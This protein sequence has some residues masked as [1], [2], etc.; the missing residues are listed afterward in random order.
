[1]GLETAAI[2][3]I[4]TA[5]ASAG[6]SAGQAI[7]ASQAARNASSRATKAFDEAMNE[8]SANR[9]AGLSLPREAME[10][11]IEAN[12]SAGAD[13][14]QAGRESERGAAAI[15]GQVYRGQTEAQREIAGDIGKQLMGLEAATAEEE[16]RLAGARANLNLAEAQG[17]Q[18][19]AAQAGAQSAAAVKGIFTGLESA[20][21]QYLEASELYKSSEGVKQYD[22][23][24]KQY[25]KAAA[26][27]TLNK[28]FL[29]PK[30]N[31]PLPFNMVISKLTGNRDIS[32]K[33]G[34]MDAL[35]AKDYLIKSPNIIKSISGDVFSRGYDTGMDI[36]APKRNLSSSLN[37]FSNP[38]LGFNTNPFGN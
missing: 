24:L 11:Q 7:S 14:T 32:N 9:I 30:T 1:M 31:Q 5:I 13:I 21:Q 27:K 19:A 36:L 12:L 33:I 37:A 34:S 25:E 17:A 3:G 4:S 28:Q 26:D 6:A 15:A 29:D 10:R 16:T 23:L 2:I 18:Q 8:L 38:S 20:G 35:N 22:S